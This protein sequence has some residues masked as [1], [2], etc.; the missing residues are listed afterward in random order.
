MSPLTGLETDLMPTLSIN[1]SSLAGLFR[2]PLTGISQSCWGSLHT[3]HTPVDP[4]FQRISD[5][6]Q[7][8][9]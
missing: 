2:R 8:H 4:D 6:E 3:A 1:I 5:K 7:S 9:A